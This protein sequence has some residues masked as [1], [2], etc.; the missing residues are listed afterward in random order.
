MVN[1]IQVLR[2]VAA[3]AV[4]WRHMMQWFQA[5]LGYGLPYVGRAGVDIFFVISGFIM[6]HTT[7]NG[8]RSTLQFWV[9]RVIRVGPVYWLITGVLIVFFYAGLSAGGVV[10]FN[11]GDIAANFLFIPKIRADGDWNPILSTGWTMVFEMYFYF[12]F[13]LTFFLRSQVKALVALAIF[14]TVAFLMTSRFWLSFTLFRWNQPITFEFVA[15][16]VL[17]LL[18]R[19]PIAL[20][21]TSA[22]LAGISLLVLGAVAFFIVA[23]LFKEGTAEP[24]LLRTAVNG[25]PAIAV[26][27]GALMLEKHGVVWNSRKLLLLGAASYSI[28]CVH[29]LVIEWGSILWPRLHLEFPGA[30]PLFCAATY[31]AAVLA[32]LVLYFAFEKPVTAFLKSKLGGRRPGAV[33]STAAPA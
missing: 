30:L 33:R 1:N 26:V 13:G 5:D 19:R 4:V 6:F 22:K 3:L 17:A 24:T 15:G 20:S 27:A 16:G 12:L 8:G 21:K 23:D 28:Y 2:A 18:Y 29:L 14:F 10:K 7:Q 32:G 31:A 25:P 9:D 11:A